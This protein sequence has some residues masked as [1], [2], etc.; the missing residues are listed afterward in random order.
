MIEPLSEYARVILALIREYP[1][2]EGKQI[3]TKL[4]IDIQRIM[5]GTS[6]LYQ[7]DLI[8]VQFLHERKSMHSE[9]FEI[10]RFY[11]R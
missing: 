11:A 6:E 8:R 9:Y 7:K 5:K 2:I 1:G 10:A 4:G 3:G